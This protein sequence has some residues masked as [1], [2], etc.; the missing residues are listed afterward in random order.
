MNKI[1]S[2]FLIPGTNKYIEAG[3]FIDPYRKYFAPLNLVH[4]MKNM[5]PINKND[6]ELLEIH[7]PSI[8]LFD[9][10][11]KQDLELSKLI[12]SYYLKTIL[13]WLC[14]SI[15]KEQWTYETLYDRFIHFIDYIIVCLEPKM[16]KTLFYT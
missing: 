14:E 6:N 12:C 15:D 8:S 3:E 16:F 13:F 11:V 1:D 7:G 4:W 2:S 10:H 5:W 9:V